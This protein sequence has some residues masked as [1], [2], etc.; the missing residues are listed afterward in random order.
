ML[1]LVPSTD[2]FLGKRLDVGRRDKP[3]DDGWEQRRA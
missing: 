3:E 2:D 1:G